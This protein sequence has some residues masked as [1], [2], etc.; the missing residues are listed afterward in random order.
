MKLF[1]IHISV[2]GSFYTIRTVEKTLASLDT[3]RNPLKTSNL[4]SFTLVLA[5]S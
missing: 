5:L 1:S 2:L 3:G 4:P